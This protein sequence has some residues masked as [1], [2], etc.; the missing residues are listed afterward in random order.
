MTNPTGDEM[1]ET[2]WKPDFK[3]KCGYEEASEKARS[4]GKCPHCGLTRPSAEG[5]KVSETDAERAV[6]DAAISWAVTERFKTVIPHANGR[7][8]AE[9]VDAL[10]AARARR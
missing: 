4:Y 3:C 7:K 9:A 10:V 6:L 1:I 5:K 8:L 2:G